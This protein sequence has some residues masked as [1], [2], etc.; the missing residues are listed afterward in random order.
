MRGYSGRLLGLY[1]LAQRFRH[2]DRPPQPAYLVLSDTQGGFPRKGF[3]FGQAQP[4]TYWVDLHR[5][6]RISGRAGAM[7][8]IFPHELLHII[9][10]V[11]AG[12]MPNSPAT[13]VHAVGVRTDRVTAFNEGFAEH[14]Q[15]MAIDDPDALAETTALASDLPLRAGAFARMKDYRRAIAAR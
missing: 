4:D 11:L 7:D 14:G 15:L 8:Q 1:A 2:P 6:G 5:R 9:V 13:Q 10:G 12:E 3:Y